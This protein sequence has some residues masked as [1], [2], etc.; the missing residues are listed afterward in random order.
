MSSSCNTGSGKTKPSGA[1]YK[2]LREKRQDESEKLLTKIP[3]LTN[4]FSQRREREE[5]KDESSSLAPEK[6]SVDTVDKNDITESESCVGEEKKSALEIEPEQVSNEN[7]ETVDT[8]IVLPGFEFK[9]DP[10]L[11]SVSEELRDY[12]AQHGAPQNRQTD[13]SSSRRQY[14]PGPDRYLTDKLFSRQLKNG[15]IINRNWMVYSP[16]KGCIFCVP[17]LL[18]GGQTNAFT[19]GFNDWKNASQRLQDHENAPCHKTNLGV[20]KMRCNTKDH[21]DKNLV[22]QLDKEVQ[23]WRNVLKRVVAAVKYLTIKGLALRGSHEHLGLLDQGNFLG[24][25]EFLADFDPFLAEHLKQHGDGGSGNTSYISKSTYEEIIILM[26]QNVCAKIIEEVKEAKYFGIVVDS[27]PDI[28][29]IDQ[30]TLV[31]RYVTVDGMPVERFLCFLPNVGH[32]SEEIVTAIVGVF[33]E[34]GLDVTKCRGQSYDN[35]SNM[36]GVYSGVQ[37]RIKMLCPHAEY[38]PCAAHSLNLVGSLAA[39]SCISAVSFFGI[40]QEL[41]N[42]FTSSTHRWQLYLNHKS[43]STV[44]LQSLSKTRWSARNDACRALKENWPAILETLQLIENDSNEKPSCRG[45]ASALRSMLET[46]EMAFL[47]IFWSSVLERFK[48]VSTKLQYETVIL[49]KV[50]GYFRS[51]ADFVTELRYD[52]DR[53]ETLAKEK[54]GLYEY[55]YESQRKRKRTLAP[56]ECKNNDAVQPVLSGSD[57]FRINTFYVMTDSLSAELERRAEKYNNLQS[58]FGF[59]EEIKH[60]PSSKISEKATELWKAY[61]NDLEPLVVDECLHLKAFLGQTNS[62]E[63]ESTDVSL[64]ELSKFIRK[65]DIM[66]VYPNVEIALRMALSTPATNCTGER[67]FSTLRRIKNYLRCIFI[68]LTCLRFYSIH[69]LPY[70]NK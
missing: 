50:R 15:E 37:A 66:D 47:S 55:K 18:F 14:P 6:S 25:I 63:K 35:A 20:L 32:K 48:K 61:P 28:S 54:S 69:L 57:N 26:S 56:D 43:K 46:L 1:Q 24:L 67:S 68:S 70:G 13:Y 9:A 2:K 52:F 41:Y 31:L 58:T 38:V 16:T 4:Y 23:Y 8:D 49:S 51:L 44:V 39:G 62:G 64:I 40:L 29:H 12:V 60:S 3:K 59:L 34:F 11:W 22:E 36:S 30:L 53:L 5:D 19:T 21:V 45:E 33:E 17:C 27:S 42:F 65:E 10:G 7:L